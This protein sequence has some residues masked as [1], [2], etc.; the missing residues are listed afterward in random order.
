MIFV[1][2]IGTYKIIREGKDEP[3]ILQ[4][5]TIIES[6]TGWF[7]VVCSNDKHASNKNR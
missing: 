5:L 1:Y 2:I 6:A 7:K 4:N 3:L